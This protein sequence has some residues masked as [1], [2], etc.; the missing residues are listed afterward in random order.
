MC[1]V[2][3]GDKPERNNILRGK[4][5][6]NKDDMFKNV[7]RKESFGH[8]DIHYFEVDDLTN[9]DPEYLFEIALKDLEKIP[10]GSAT[11]WFEGEEKV[12]DGDTRKLW[13][14]RNWRDVCRYSV[15]TGCDEIHVQEDGSWDYY[16]YNSRQHHFQQEPIQ[17]DYR[18]KEGDPAEVN[19]YMIPGMTRFHQGRCTRFEDADFTQTSWTIRPQGCTA[20]TFVRIDTVNGPGPGFDLGDSVRCRLSQ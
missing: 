12:D 4:S 8:L 5:D 16:S 9:L 17:G 15:V 13:S 19:I 14:C 7:T 3:T 10:R 6:N 18:I 20:Y 11:V 1:G 2:A